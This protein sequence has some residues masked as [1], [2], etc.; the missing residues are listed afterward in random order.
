[1]DKKEL[2]YRAGIVPIVENTYGDSNETLL[3]QRLQRVAAILEDEEESTDDSGEKNGDRYGHEVDRE[4][5]EIDR[6]S[7][8]SSENCKGEIK[9]I[10]DSMLICWTDLRKCIMDCT[11][12]GMDIPDTMNTSIDKL[13]RAIE[14]LEQ[15]AG[16]V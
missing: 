13:G 7:G 1:M 12:D 10:H 14:E 5:D 2:Q 4:G 16:K 8:L 15:L 6:N 3:R 9:K 11:T